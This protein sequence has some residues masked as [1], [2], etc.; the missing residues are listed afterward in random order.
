M[1]YEGIRKPGLAWTGKSDAV[2]GPKRKLVD[3]RV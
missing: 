2:E 3:L 1:L